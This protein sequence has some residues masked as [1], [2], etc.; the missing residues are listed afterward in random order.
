MTPDPASP[1]QHPLRRVLDRDPRGPE[2]SSMGSGGTLWNLPHPSVPTS[3]ASSETRQA[4]ETL[5]GARVSFSVLSAGQQ[6]RPPPG[7]SRA[8]DP[9]PD[10]PA[11][12]GYCA[13]PVTMKTEPPSRPGRLLGVLPPRCRCAPAAVT[14]PS[15]PLGPLESAALR[16]AVPAGAPQPLRA[17][18]G[19]GRRPHLDRLCVRRGA[20]TPVE[21]SPRGPGHPAPPPASSR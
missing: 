21:G 14:Q 6:H 8:A 1:D 3:L 7:R 5:A 4:R 20:G 11:D 10:S 9:A 19:W 17:A 12:R 13:R 16:D 15:G 18:D 2:S